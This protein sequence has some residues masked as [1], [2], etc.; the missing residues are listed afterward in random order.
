MVGFCKS[1]DLMG[2]SD[3]F[4]SVSLFSVHAVKHDGPAA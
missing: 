4:I 2:R 1:R 3:L